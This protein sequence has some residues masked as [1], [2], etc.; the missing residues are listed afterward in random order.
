MITVDLNLT[1]LTVGLS[2]MLHIG[3]R[4]NINN[5]ESEEDITANVNS[6]LNSSE[7]THKQP[8]IEDV[9]VE[10][11]VLPQE[12]FIFAASIDTSQAEQESSLNAELALGTSQTRVSL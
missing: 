5:N 2:L 7:C 3:L 12:S 11:T 6:G 10:A 8:R 4:D 1:L 9:Q